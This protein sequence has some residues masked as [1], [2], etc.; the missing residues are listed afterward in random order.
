[1]QLQH[2]MEKL[3]PAYDELD[4]AFDILSNF[5]QYW[6]DCGDDI[7][8]QHELIKLVVER[9]YVD[10]RRVFALTLKS[11]YHFILGHN[12]NEP[13]YSEVDPLAHVWAQRDLNSRPHGCEPCALAS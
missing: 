8:K 5:K 1:M 10:G 13:T 6:L 4:R 9:I 3:T 11:D 2:E 12:A 7:E